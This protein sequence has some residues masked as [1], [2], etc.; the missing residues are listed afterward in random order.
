[1]FT[2]EKTVGL[3]NYYSVQARKWIRRYLHVLKVSHTNMATNC[4]QKEEPLT[5]QWQP[6]IY[7]LNQ[8][9]GYYQQQRVQA[10]RKAHQ[11]YAIP[12]DCKSK[13][14][15]ANVNR[16]AT[17][18]TTL[19]LY[20]YQS[21][22]EQNLRTSSRGRNKCSLWPCIDSLTRSFLFVLLLWRLQDNSWNVHEV[23]SN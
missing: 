23:V 16:K 2:N 15:E 22:E 6:D 1:M 18:K 10:Q 20:T 19:P 4:P 13:E 8:A 7:H 3:E 5:L 14:D 11:F 21:T 9:L 17:Y 12:A